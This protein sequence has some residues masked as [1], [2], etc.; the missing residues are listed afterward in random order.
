MIFK[1]CNNNNI[2]TMYNSTNSGTPAILN[3]IRPSGKKT[4]WA[5]KKIR[6][7]FMA[8]H[9]D[10]ITSLRK[11][12]EKM[13]ECGRTL[14]FARTDTGHLKLY[15][16]YFCKVRLC[17]MCAWRRSL[18][19]A[20]HN[21]AI[22]AYANALHGNLSWIFLTLTVKNCDGKSLPD[23][24]NMMMKAFNVF[25]GRAKYKRVIIGHFRV[26]EI[27]KNHKRNDYH[28]HFHVLLCVDKNYFKSKDYI[29]KK[30]WTDM[31]QTALKAN[32]TPIVD[33][34]KVRSKKQTNSLNILQSYNQAKDDLDKAVLEISKYTVKDTDILRDKSVTVRNINTVYDVAKA[35]ERKRLIAY[36]GLLKEIHHVLNFKDDDDLIKCGLQD[37][38]DEAEIVGDVIARWH[39]G[40]KNYV[41]S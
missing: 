33:V 28:P 4:D 30:E 25:T 32:Y 12:A 17:P 34:R 3:D 8:D 15:K 27:T 6:N 29:N 10:V 11:R 37:D 23:T 31:W 38:D 7:E 41:I 24:V 5:G 18:Q 21:K 9:Y 40:I 16:A 2:Q 26:L 14:Q 13:R 19:I 22:L 20:A 36:G 1:L 39:P 35:I